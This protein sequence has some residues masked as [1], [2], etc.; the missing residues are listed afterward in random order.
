MDRD[1]RRFGTEIIFEFAPAGR[2]LH[3]QPDFGKM[4]V[5][6]I[7]N[8]GQLDERVAYYIQ[9]KD[10]TIYFGAEGLTFALT[11]ADEERN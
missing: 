8:R 1:T 5:N 2:I 9:G 7:P 10:K 11:K 3:A 6:F 4:P